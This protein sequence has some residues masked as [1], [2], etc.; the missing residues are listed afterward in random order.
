MDTD[1]STFVLPDVSHIG[2][3][4]NNLDKTIRELEDLYGLKPHIVMEPGYVDTYLRGK[5]VAFKLKSAFYRAGQ[6]F[7][8]VISVLE[9]DSIYGEWLR[10]KGEGLH[11]LGYDI[12]DIEKWI[13]HYKSKGIEVI[14]R[15][16]RPGVKWAYLDT[17]PYT[18]VIIELIERTEAG[19]ILK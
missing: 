11:H 7:Y 12:D 1:Q 2:M 19:Q 5:P 6:V 17:A 10:E 14:Q 18:G 16:G 13:T 9:G 4:T 15:G 3:V 8:E